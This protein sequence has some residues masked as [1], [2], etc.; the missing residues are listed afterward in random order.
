MLVVPSCCTTRRGAGQG[1]RAVMKRIQRRLMNTSFKWNQA[2]PGDQGLRK[3]K[4]RFLRRLASQHKSTLSLVNHGPAVAV[5]LRQ[6]GSAYRRH[7]VDQ[8]LRGPSSKK[9]RL[10]HQRCSSVSYLL[11]YSNAPLF[12]ASNWQRILGSRSRA[13]AYRPRIGAAS[14]WRSLRARTVSAF[15]P[16]SRRR[17]R[18]TD[19]TVPT[20]AERTGSARTIAS[21]GSGT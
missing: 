18:T 20:T 11:F 10:S 19:F 1:V 2:A 13:P 7:R 5:A 15:T 14:E 9:P 17:I 6:D 21:S 16:S 12:G 3:G 8:S 4:R